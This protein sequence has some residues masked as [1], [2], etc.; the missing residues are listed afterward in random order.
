MAG[1][2]HLICKATQTAVFTSGI[3]Q[4][5]SAGA[6]HLTEYCVDAQTG[7]ALHFEGAHSSLIEFYAQLQQQSMATDTVGMFGFVSGESTN[8]LA[9][10]PGALLQPNHAEIHPE[11][12]RGAP[13]Q[14]D[15][16]IAEG[17][18]TQTAPMDWAQMMELLGVHSY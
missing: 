15:S 7:R 13:L 9:H 16:L 4:P 14:D 11:S 17:L 5:D 2:T 3:H 12:I 18:V 6:S 1:A 10:A 8:R